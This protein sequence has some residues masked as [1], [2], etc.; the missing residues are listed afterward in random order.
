M[1]VLPRSFSLPTAS[2]GGLVG[3]GCGVGEGWG[4]GAGRGQGGEE[5]RD[6]ARGSGGI[7]GRFG[8][9]S[10]AGGVGVRRFGRVGMIA[11]WRA[12]RQEGGKGRE[13]GV[14]WR[15]Q[16]CGGR[17]GD[18]A[19]G[20]AEGSHDRGLHRPRAGERIHG[21]RVIWMSSHVRRPAMARLPLSLNRPLTPS[22]S[23]TD[24]SK[25]LSQVGEREKGRGVSACFC[26][27]PSMV[28]GSWAGSWG[29]VGGRR[30]WRR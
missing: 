20:E 22:L 3:R 21:S 23:P 13:G 14:I 2:L 8:S 9:G 7:G 18:A 30:L 16:L 19:F 1:P 17:G 5:G 10:A 24:A 12:G 4:R 27:D 15:R 28:T 11:G 29:R 25:A 6:H 26:T